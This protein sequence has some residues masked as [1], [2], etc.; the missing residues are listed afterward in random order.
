MAGYG[1]TG[2]FSFLLSVYG[3]NAKRFGHEN[4]EGKKKRGSITY[5]TDRA[6]EANNMF[7]TNE[8]SN[9]FITRL[10]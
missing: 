5:C 2:L 1:R 9:M 4:K 8:A 3:P 6:N 10:C 7:I